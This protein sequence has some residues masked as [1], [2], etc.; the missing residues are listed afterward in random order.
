MGFVWNIAGLIMTEIGQMRYDV[1]RK[2]LK[3]KQ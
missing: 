2:E 1:K 3:I